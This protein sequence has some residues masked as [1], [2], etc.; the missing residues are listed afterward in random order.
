MGGVHRLHAR[1]RLDLCEGV[2]GDTGILQQCLDPVE[3]P[4]LGN[5]RIGHHQDAGAHPGHELGQLGQGTNPERQ[6]RRRFERKRIRPHHTRAS[7]H[8]RDLSCRVPPFPRSRVPVCLPFAPPS[9]A[10]YTTGLPVPSTPRPQR[11]ARQ[12]SSGRKRHTG[13]LLQSPGQLVAGQHAIVSPPATH[14][15]GG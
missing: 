12:T 5:A 1:I 9:T 2:S 6:P 8:E 4:G 7:P 13:A 14:P 15:R 3:D 11:P 10:R